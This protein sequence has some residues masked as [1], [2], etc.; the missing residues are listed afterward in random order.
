METRFLVDFKITNAVPL[1]DSVLVFHENGLRGLSFF[2]GSIVQDLN[3]PIKLF[4]VIGT[5]K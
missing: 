2:N 5:E 3:D 4:T 1:S